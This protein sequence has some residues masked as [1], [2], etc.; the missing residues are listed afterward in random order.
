MEQIASAGGSASPPTAVTPDPSFLRQVEKAGGATISPCFQCVKCSSGCPLT[1]VMDLLPN[2]V[3]RCVQ[4]GLKEEVLRSDTIWLCASCE[5]CTTRCPNGVD[6][7]HLMDTLRQ[8]ALRE[9]VTPSQPGIVATHAAF[10]AEIRARGRV[11]EMFL[12]ARH[13]LRTRN[14]TR[15]VALGWEMFR[16]GK[17]KLLPKGVKGRKWLKERVP[18]VN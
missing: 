12:V 14:W 11:H 15:D 3:I 6:I 2:Q 18:R 17:L 5:T 9:N 8:I 7:A 4:V 13:K 1:F 16:R 10:L